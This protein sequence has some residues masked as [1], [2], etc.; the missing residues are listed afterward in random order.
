MNTKKILITND[1]GIEAVGLWTLVRA[2]ENIAEITVVAPDKEQSATSH[3]ITI[4]EPIWMKEYQTHEGKRG[5]A[6]GGTP[7]DCVKL[8]LEVIVDS[9]PDLI[10]SG[11][12]LGSNAGIN[13]LYSGTVA[14]AL[15]GA[16][17][18][19]P[20]IAVSLA[21]YTDPVF[22]FAGKFTKNIVLDVLK[23]GWLKKGFALNIN[24]PAVP[25]EKI[26]GARVARQGASMF[27]ENFERRLSPSGGVYFW[28][29]GEKRFNN[30]PENTDEDLIRQNIIS[31]TPIRPDITAHSE[32]EHIAS[33]INRQ[34]SVNVTK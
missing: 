33:K 26:R 29:S 18:Q 24:I 25:E 15:E 10:I 4:H 8:A 19:I 30:V 32:I 13:A 14:A 9:K 7:T 11:I 23:N 2:L 21:T 27:I 3:S 5:F 28:M 22:D 34:T 31:I 1:D 17:Q 6:V 16:I 12:N 20:S